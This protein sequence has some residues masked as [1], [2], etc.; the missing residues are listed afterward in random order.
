MRI[1]RSYEAG[2]ELTLHIIRHQ[3]SETLVVEAPEDAHA[4]AYRSFFPRPD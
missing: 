2:E 4:S 3:R 1:L